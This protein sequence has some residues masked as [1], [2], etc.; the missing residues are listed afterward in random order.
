MKRLKQKRSGFKLEPSEVQQE[1]LEEGEEGEKA[2]KKS[3]EIQVRKATQPLWKKTKKLGN[4]RSD[5]AI[6]FHPVTSFMESNQSREHR[7]V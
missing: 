4:D 7:S 3:E 2:G 6:V 5:A 1:H